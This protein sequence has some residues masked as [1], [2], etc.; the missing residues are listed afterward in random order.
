MLISWPMKRLA[1]PILLLAVTGA[2]SG[3]N[4]PLLVEPERITVNTPIMVNWKDVL[5]CDSAPTI[6]VS[7][8]VV[9][10]DF[11]FQSFCGVVPPGACGENRALIGNLPPGSYTLIAIGHG[12]HRSLDFDVLPVS[13]FSLSVIGRWAAV[14]LVLGLGFVQLL[15]RSNGGQQAGAAKRR[16]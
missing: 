15:N 9:T 14:L 6:D 7:G 3:G 4:C 11:N 10:V 1:L 2:A 8:S 16:S 5:V 12:R 13:I